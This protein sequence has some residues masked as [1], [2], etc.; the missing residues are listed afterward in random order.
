MAV[1]D[2]IGRSYGATRRPDPRI[3]AQIHAALDGMASVLDVGA[4]AG[5]YEPP[6]TVLG[7][8]P[9]AVMIAQ[10]RAGAARPGRPQRETPG[11]ARGD[12]RTL[13]PPQGRR[14]RRHRRTPL[15]HTAHPA[16]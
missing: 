13:V 9:S 7:V 3:A 4:G 15:T 14:V 10:R 11:L 2:R 8:E 12:G 16:C 1:Y 6:S 5:S